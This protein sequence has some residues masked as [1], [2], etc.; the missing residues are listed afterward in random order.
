M[1]F[2]W[3]LRSKVS[4][5]SYSDE[6]EGVA[7]AITLKPMRNMYLR[8]VSADGPVLLSAPLGTSAEVIRRFVRS[9][10]GWIQAHRARLAE[11]TAEPPAGF[12]RYL[13]NLVAEAELCGPI[14]PEGRMAV[15][16]ARFRREIHEQL[17]Q[18][19]GIWQPRMG[20]YAESWHVRRMKSRWGS[21]NPVTRRLCFNAEL[22]RHSPLCI[23]YVVVHELAHLAERGHDAAFW[24]VVAAALPDW[25]LRRDMLRGRQG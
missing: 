3:N 18:Y 24:A 2:L 11:K 25:K 10:L 9:R 8:V 5:R 14:A 23:E 17:T 7:L 15:L 21:C 20:L 6:V 1:S 22:I 13:G 19:L 12:V 4:S 16:Q